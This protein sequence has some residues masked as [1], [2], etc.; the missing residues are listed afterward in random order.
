MSS[1]SE[2]LNGTFSLGGTAIVCL[3]GVGFEFDRELTEMAY[4]GEDHVTDVLDGVKHY[5]GNIKSA[6]VDN[7]YIT[8]WNSGTPLIGTLAPRGGTTPTI[9]G[10]IKFSG[11][12]L[13]GMEMENSAA[14]F[15]D[16]NFVMYNV[17]LS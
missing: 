2:G 9:V 6:Y 11:G 12:R 13:E 8:I 1:A 7:R 16:I 15:E 17:T 5:R 10:T 14:V 3:A 4:M